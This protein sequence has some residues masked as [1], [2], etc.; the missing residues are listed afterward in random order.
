[1]VKLKHHSKNMKS[2]FYYCLL[3]QSLNYMPPA[4]HITAI[5]SSNPLPFLRPE[6][7]QITIST[8]MP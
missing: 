8:G 3:V 6:K 1:M 5:L 4:E 2:H 7:V